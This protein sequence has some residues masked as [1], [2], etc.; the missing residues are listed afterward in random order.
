MSPSKRADFSFFSSSCF[1]LHSFIP[2]PDRQWCDQRQS[3]QTTGD[4]KRNAKEN[5]QPNSKSGRKSN[6]RFDKRALRLSCVLRFCGR[7]CGCLCIVIKGHLFGAVG[8]S[9]ESTM[10][11]IAASERKRIRDEKR[12]KLR[13]KKPNAFQYNRMWLNWSSETVMYVAQKFV[14]VSGTYENKCAE[15]FWCFRCWRWN[16]FLSNSVSMRE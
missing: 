9:H 15:R 5:N 10:W 3:S 1:F 7:G 6:L 11:K 2:I 8:A 4:E 13:G 16:R 12:K 14:E